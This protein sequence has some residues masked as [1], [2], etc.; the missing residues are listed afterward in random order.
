MILITT[1]AIYTFP[2]DFEEDEHLPVA[3]EETLDANDGFISIYIHYKYN[4]VLY[5]QTHRVSH[6]L[7]PRDLIEKVLQKFN[8]NNRTDEKPDDYVL[9]ELGSENYFLGYSE[10]ETDIYREPSLIQYK[11]YFLYKLSQSSIR[12][13]DNLA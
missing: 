2:P 9:K 3:L 10:N 7:F 13:G 12:N 1:R 5:K 4:Q 8:L 11:V 6:K